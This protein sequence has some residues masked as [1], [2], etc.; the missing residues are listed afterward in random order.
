MRA[1]VKRPLIEAGM[2]FKPGDW[3]EAEPDRL[4]RLAELGYVER[5]KAPSP[6]AKSED[7]P[8]RNK[9]VRKP[10]KKK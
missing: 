1:K 4:D 10:G 9:Q 8:P 3:L 2:R 5:Q 6:Q 7:G